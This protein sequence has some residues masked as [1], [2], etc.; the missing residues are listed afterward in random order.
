MKPWQRG[1]LFT[2]GWKTAHLSRKNKEVEEEGEE[3]EEEEKDVEEE[4]EEIEE[5]AEE[6]EK[7]EIE[8]KGS[9]FGIKEPI[10]GE[11]KNIMEFFRHSRNYRE[12]RRK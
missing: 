4:D 11:F 3:T 10:E 12:E 6:N 7:C 1:D 2:K 9:A 8:A 5:E